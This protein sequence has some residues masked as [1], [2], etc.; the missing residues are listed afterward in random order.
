MKNQAFGGGQNRLGVADRLAPSERGTEVY[1]CTVNA[2][3]YCV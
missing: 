2:T 3:E 1:F